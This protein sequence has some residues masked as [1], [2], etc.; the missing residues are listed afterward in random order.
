MDMLQQYG[1]HIGYSIHPNERGKGYGKKILKLTLKEAKENH[2]NRVLVNCDVSNLASAR[3]IE[4]NNGKLEN[5][6]V[7]NSDG[8]LVRRY[9]INFQLY[10]LPN[11]KG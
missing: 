4:A 7:D 5:K 2:L 9:W 11:Q 6:I 1:G 3:V 8:T 10:L